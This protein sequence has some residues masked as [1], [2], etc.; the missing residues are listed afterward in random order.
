[1]TTRLLSE[2]STGRLWGRL[3]VVNMTCFCGFPL[4][5]FIH[6]DHWSLDWNELLEKNSELR[7][8]PRFEVKKMWGRGEFRLF[9]FLHLLFGGT[10]NVSISSGDV[11]G[12]A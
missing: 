7:G 12:K 9:G 5:V 8:M 4:V 2:M 11:I 3:R 6:I 10:S 1:M